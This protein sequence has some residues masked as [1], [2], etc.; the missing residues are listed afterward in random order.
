MSN[1]IAVLAAMCALG[2]CA[3]TAPA[4]QP[5]GFEPNDPLPGSCDLIE[6]HPAACLTYVVS[7]TPVAPNSGNC[8]TVRVSGPAQSDVQVL[9]LKLSRRY[10]A[11]SLLCRA[12]KAPAIKCT[13]LDKTMTAG[14]GT[15][16]VA[17]RLPHDFTA[18]RIACGIAAPTGFTCKLRR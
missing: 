11:L 3:G 7:C 6:V 1:R 14:G 12:T 15:R 10:S 16:T 17:L 18:V 9:A 4:Q 2:V 8:S 13:A 5:P